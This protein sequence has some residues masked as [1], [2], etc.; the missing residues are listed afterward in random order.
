MPSGT[1]TVESQAWNTAVD[2]MDSDNFLGFTGNVVTNY[3]SG[4]HFYARLGPG[5][6]ELYINYTNPILF[7]DVS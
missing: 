6:P 5:R 2:S 1:A 7:Y 3:R 4:I